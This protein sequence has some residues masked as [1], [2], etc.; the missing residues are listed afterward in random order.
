MREQDKVQQGSVLMHKTK[1]V[2]PRGTICPKCRRLG[3][4]V[5]MGLSDHFGICTACKT[6]NIGLPPGETACRDCSGKLVEVGP[7]PDDALLPQYCPACAED[8]ATSQKMVAEGG[9]IWECRDC[10]NSGAFSGEHPISELT[11]KETGC[12]SPE[13]CGVTLSEENCPV[14]Q[15]GGLN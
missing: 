9:V 5:M 12:P 10:H 4:Q 8:I 14:C 2:N 15:R 3:P 1:G 13:P 6:M 7:I 11:R